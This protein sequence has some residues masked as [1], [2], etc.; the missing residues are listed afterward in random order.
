MQCM[1]IFQSVKE[2]SIRP[3]FWYNKGN[4]GCNYGTMEK[5]REK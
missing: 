5:R 1:L 4:G 3:R 2:L